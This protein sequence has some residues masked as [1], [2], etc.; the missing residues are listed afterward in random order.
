M[1][2]VRIALSAKTEI[3]MRAFYVERGLAVTQAISGAGWRVTHLASGMALDARPFPQRQQARA[4]Q[5]A[6]LALAVDWTVDATALKA[7]PGMAASVRGLH[8]AHL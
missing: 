8:I 2:T 3:H 4:F 5:L 1:A 6:L 7:T